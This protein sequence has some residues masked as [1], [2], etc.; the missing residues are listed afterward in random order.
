[1]FRE[2]CRIGNVAFANRVLRSSMG[3]RNCYL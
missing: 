2:P 3:G 1:M